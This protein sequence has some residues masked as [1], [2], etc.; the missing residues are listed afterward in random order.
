MPLLAVVAQ[1]VAP[2]SGYLYIIGA[3]L[4]GGMLACWVALAAQVPFRARLSADEVARLPLRSPGGAA[5]SRLGFAALAVAI[6]PTWWVDQ[7]RITIVSGVPYLLILTVAYLAT[8]G[9]RSAA[10]TAAAG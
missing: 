1:K 9:R 8:R 6:A 4:F 5:A 3:A 7:S 10:S 2:E